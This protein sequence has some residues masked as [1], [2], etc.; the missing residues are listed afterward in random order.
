M[1]LKIVLLLQSNMNKLSP[2]NLKKNLLPLFLMLLLIGQ[3]FATF[4]ATPVTPLPEEDFTDG[5]YLFPDHSATTEEG[6]DSASLGD[7]PFASADGSDPFELDGPDPLEDPRLL[8]E[9]KQM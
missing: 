6:T 8:L 4:S 3:P 5:G 9:Q 2:R 1:K 7:D